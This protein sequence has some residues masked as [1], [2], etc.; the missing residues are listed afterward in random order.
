MDRLLTGW[1]DE[2]RANFRDTPRDQLLG[3][4][5]HGLGTGIRN[6]FGLWRGNTELLADCGHPEM[7]ADA[8]SS[9]IL[10]AVWNKL[11]NIPLDDGMV[12][13]YKTEREAYQEL[14]PEKSYLRFVRD[15]GSEEFAREAIG[16]FFGLDHEQVAEVA[17]RARLMENDTSDAK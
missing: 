6:E 1:S 14:G 10:K 4:F 15:T 11:H 9:V 2:S 13:N 8:A 12:Q 5:H 16:H 7:H 3:R 17:S